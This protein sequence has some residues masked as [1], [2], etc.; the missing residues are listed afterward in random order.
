LWWLQCSRSGS[1]RQALARPA[2]CQQPTEPRVCLLL[3]CR[4][5]LRKSKAPDISFIL[6]ALEN[7]LPRLRQEQLMVLEST[8]DPGTTEEVVQPR[9][10]ALGFVIGA[11]FFL[12]FSPERVDPG[13]Q[14]FT[15]A[16]IPKVVGGVTR[17]PL[18]AS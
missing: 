15:T 18:P 7:L 12:A 9:L 3:G 16:N 17:E 10:Q 4:T 11:D 2:H 1:E 14:R 5:P 8:T 13:N 6:S